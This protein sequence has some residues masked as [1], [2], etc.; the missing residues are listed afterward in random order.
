MH[1]GA[2]L[3]YMKSKGLDPRPSAPFILHSFDGIAAAVFNFKTLKCP[4][5]LSYD[6]ACPRARAIIQHVQ[7]EAK[8]A[9]KNLQGLDLEEY[10]V[11]LAG[12]E[13]HS[14][15]VEDVVGA[16]E[17]NGLFGFADGW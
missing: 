2:L 15:E 7:D 1:L 6:P 4:D 5:Q 3:K 14:R 12:A 16:A 8:R 9:K 17:E 10:L 13:A 11:D